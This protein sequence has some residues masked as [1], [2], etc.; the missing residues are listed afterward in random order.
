M[1]S[2]SSSCDRRRAH[3]EPRSRIA[4]AFIVGGVGA[5][6]VTAPASAADAPPWMH[7]LVGV[8]LPSYKDT[9]NAVLLYSEDIVTVQ[10]PGRLLVRSRKAY[11]ILRPEGEALSTVQIPFDDQTRI[12]DIH[13]WC[14]P[15][16]GKDISV[17][18][19]DTAETALPGLENGYLVSDLQSKVMHIPGA[20][21]GSVIGWEVE[22][23]VVPYSLNSEWDPEDTIPVR[24][25]RY[26]LALPAGWTYHASWINHPEVAPVESAAGSARQFQ[27]VMSDLAA[28]PIEK[29]MPPWRGIAPRMVI[30]VA[31]SGTQS[32]GWNSWADLGNWY[33]GLIGNRRDPSAEIRAQV[34]QLTA[35]E[36]T[37][38]GRIRAVSRFVQ[39]DI[40]YVAIELGIGGHQPH[41]A[42]EVFAHR[43]GDCKD[44]ANLLGAMLQVI[45]VESFP[46][47][48]NTTRGTV[49]PG[50]PA[51][52][53]FD[54]AILAI[55]LP[56]GVDAA[57]LP[58]TVT[59]PKLGKLLFFDPT[60]PLTPLGRLAGDLQS[61][62]ALLVQPDT[63]ELV[64]LPQLSS[65]SS[66]VRRTATMALDEAGTLSGDIVETHLGDAAKLQRELIRSMPL[67][68]DR[69]KPVEARVANS[70]STFQIVKA[71]VGN[72]NSLEQPFE[73][74]YSIEA[75][76][77]A[78]A[79]GGLLLVRPRVVGVLAQGFLETREDR[80]EPIEFEG[81]TR[82]TDVVDITLP[83]HYKV[84]ELPPPVNADYGFAT[85]RSKTELAGGKLHFSRSFEIKQVSLPASKAGE[86]KELFRIIADDERN[87]AVLVRTP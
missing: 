67:D 71:A 29:Y 83:E 1:S 6:S 27:W 85:Y 84:D 63:S 25:A 72:A 62:Y 36:S 56:P 33:L 49:M 15:T 60:D 52:T 74:H 50:M 70:I 47:M 69:I 51:N 65:D 10:A 26:T 58:A 87:T 76:H 86:L 32:S 4:L 34:T 5:L 2:R 79:T 82:D 77:Y 19:K 12:T 48:I 55:R 46:V 80:R 31:Q 16:S 23:Q 17:K 37:A 61:N 9:T 78:R 75:P 53:D 73:W 22:Q 21:V 44:K 39:G 54:H 42:A 11:R 35:S 66:G 18:D 7:A 30:A 28:V 14:I 40:R 81:P 41:P 64:L 45:G 8:T 68:T 20:T 24:E 38:L 57:G 3:I 13:G 59:H 43:Y